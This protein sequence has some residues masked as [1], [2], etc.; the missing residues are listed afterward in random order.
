MQRPQFAVCAALLLACL[1]WGAAAAEGVGLFSADAGTTPLRPPARRL[2]AEDAGSVGGPHGNGFPELPTP[3]ELRSRSARIDIDR[4]SA[5][6]SEVAQGRPHHLRLNLFADA[7]FDALIERTAP[8]ASGYT[9][10]GRL[11]D[12]PLSMVVVAVN[13]GH[14]AGTVW[15]SRGVHSIR[16]RGGIAEIRQL[17]PMASGRCEVVEA[18]PTAHPD[19]SRKPR[20]GDSPFAP[21]PRARADAAVAPKAASRTANSAQ[22]DEGDVIDLLVVYPPFARRSQGGHQAMRV[23]I[24]QDVAVTNE[25]LRSSGV[26]FRIAL[27]AA[28]EVDYEESDAS[29]ITIAFD[30]LDGS[31]GQ[32]DDVHALRDSYAAD[33]VTLHLGDGPPRDFG[34]G[35]AEL[36]SAENYSNGDRPAFNVVSSVIPSPMAHEIGHNMGLYHDRNSVFSKPEVQGPRPVYPYGYGYVAADPSAFAET[37]GDTWRTIM[38]FNSQNIP[39]FSNSNQRW[40]DESGVPIGAPGDEWINGVEGPADAV[41]ALNN[42]R[43]YV[44]NHRASASRCTYA[45]SPAPPRLPAQGGEYRIQVGTAPGCAWTARAD[46]DGFAT[47]TAGR[48]GVGSGEAAFQVAANAGWEREVAV[49]VAGEVYAMRQAG[50]RAVTPVCE[51]PSPIS[52]A[53]S[54]AVGKPCAEVAQ[55]DLAAVRNLQ[56]AYRGVSTALGPGMLSG[57]S[58]LQWLK[59]WTEVSMHVQPGAFEGLVNLKEMYIHSRLTALPNGM[60]DGLSNLQVLSL[61]D[62]RLTVLKK[63]AFRELTNLRFLSVNAN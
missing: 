22:S 54:E 29:I 49:L 58:G 42:I 59:I 23:L 1:P 12:E 60:F 44:A 62:N 35:A 6:R 8:T 25:M 46:G 30:L 7:G 11:A 34:V 32:L 19:A 38:H 33:L 17:N 14:V 48:S 39:R 57:L 2:F 52:E 61:H 15:S 20:S 36:L 63:D 50:A 26:E 16:A 28:V 31:D 43:R 40:P 4:L 53:I 21:Q 3:R 9:L 45:L 56:F 27:V 51:R 37:G 55:S 18:P 41:R 24:E 5:A 47:L 10:T 13:G